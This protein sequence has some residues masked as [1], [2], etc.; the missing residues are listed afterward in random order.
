MIDLGETTNLTAEEAATSIAQM[1]N[2]MGTA[3][4]NVDRLGAALVA[5]GNNGASTERD[6]LEMAQRISA[7]GAQVGMTEA[8]VL[9]F[10]NALASL[11]VEAE[12]G[13]TAI[14]SVMSNMSK[15]V[16]QGGEKLEQFA[17]VAGLS[18]SE[19]ATAFRE[20]PAAAIATFVEGLAGIQAAGGDVFTTLDDMGLGSIRMRDALLRMAG[21]HR[22][23]RMT[24]EDL[25][26]P[27][28]G[29]KLRNQL[30]NMR[31]KIAKE[32]AVPLP[33]A[34]Q[35]LR[36]IK[37]GTPL[38]LEQRPADRI[39]PARWTL[40]PSE[41]PLPIRDSELLANCTVDVIGAGV[42]QAVE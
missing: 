36:Q 16:S 37:R 32:G 25:S 34:V 38:S 39:K 31:Q 29:K 20:D 42:G 8:D 30:K 12:A 14:S 7:A 40:F 26:R 5:L 4:Q 19:F 1:M 13:G 15:A 18:A 2:I 28:R 33:R 21:V 11:G 27:F 41:T 3:P 22:P 24:G 6:I 10:A 35:L 9:G 23:E 17:T